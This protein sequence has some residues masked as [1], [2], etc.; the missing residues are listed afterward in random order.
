MHFKGTGGVL[1][2]ALVSFEALNDR[3]LVGFGHG[4][5]GERLRGRERGHQEVAIHLGSD[6]GNTFGDHGG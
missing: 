2:Y 4:V 5:R 3:L 1:E 6:D